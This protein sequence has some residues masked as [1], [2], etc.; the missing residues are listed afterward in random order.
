[1]KTRARVAAL[2]GAAAAV[3]IPIG[4]AAGPAVAE[5]PLQARIQHVLLI[6]VDGM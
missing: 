3:A 4:L 1:M 6:S 5:H 2:A